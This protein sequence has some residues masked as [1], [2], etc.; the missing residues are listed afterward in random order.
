MHCLLNFFR[1]FL[2]ILSEQVVLSTMT[3]GAANDIERPV[4]I[5]RKMVSEFGMS[6]L[7][8]IYLGESQTDHQSQSLLDRVEDATNK[9]IN[10][11]LE[12]ACEVVKSKHD[13]ISPSR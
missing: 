9:I 7:G 8:P 10:T 5:A 11:Q 13:S 1:G 2:A 6:P 3:A 4:E 12:R